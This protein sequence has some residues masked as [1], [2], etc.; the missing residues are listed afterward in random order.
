[1]FG[2]QFLNQ[3]VACGVELM[4]IGNVSLSSASKKS[5]LAQPAIRASNLIEHHMFYA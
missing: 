3:R 5:A 1:M 4:K 2:L